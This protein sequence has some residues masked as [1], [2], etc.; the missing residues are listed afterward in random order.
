M[1]L[2]VKSFCTSVLLV[3]VSFFVINAQ[4]SADVMR[5][6]V[7]KAK[8]FIA[9]R[10]YNAAIYELE[11]I[12]RETSDPT[13]N[14]VINVLLMNSYLEQGDYTR[15]QEFLKELSN[16]KKI[17]L[18]GGSANYFAVAGQVVKGAKNQLERY[19]ALG[20][21]VSDR[22]LPIEASVDVQKMRETLE[23]V[24]EQS[25]T[26]GK[27]KDKTPNAMALLDEA[28]NVRS[29]LA[30]DDYDANRWKNE[31]ADA[32]EMIASSRSVIINAVNDPTIEAGKPEQNTVALN[33]PIVNPNMTA[34]TKP[35]PTNSTF[36][37]V[38]N[39]SVDKPI[40]NPAQTDKAKPAAE[41]I[42]KTENPIVPE[43]TENGN[44]EEVQKPKTE[45]TKLVPNVRE[46][47]I[48]NSEAEKTPN[49]NKPETVADN[50]ET[51]KDTS[52]MAVGSL[53]EYATQKSNPIYPT[54]AKSMRMTGVVRVE[55]V[56]DEE[57]QVSEVQKSSGPSLL[58]GAATDALKKWKFKPFTRGGEPVKAT[59]FV[60]FNFTL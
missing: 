32:R 22:T 33:Q 23:V 20:L 44:T 36:Q 13:V 7:A 5:E 37:P 9:V 16:Q 10:N 59:G 12:R 53:V 58:R 31:A 38:Q 42:A 46:R 25:K 48:E 39:S 52:P 4:T 51:P 27:E 11:N 3:L 43:K 26:L 19:R 6:R 17:N 18:P 24:V 1:P 41:T 2:K 35:N 34:E 29:T 45:E 15:A 40:T 28:T 8:A 30:K 54:T 55:V 49:Q 21:S 56:V 47:Q 60:S 50:A 57:G 14:G